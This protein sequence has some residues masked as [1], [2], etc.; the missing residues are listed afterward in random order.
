MKKKYKYN[1]ETNHSDYADAM[2]YA[3]TCFPKL[4]WYQI[5]WNWI[6]T[7]TK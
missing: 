3:F 1:P 2:M 7:L 4:K 6:K 5:L